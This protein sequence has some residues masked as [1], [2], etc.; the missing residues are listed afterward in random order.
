M[1]GSP[2]SGPSG[3]A[4]RLVVALVVATTAAAV[5]AGMALNERHPGAERPL[6]NANASQLR[7]GEASTVP[8]ETGRRAPLSETAATLTPDSVG[9]E[10][11]GGDP[12]LPPAAEALKD[13]GGAVG[14]PAPTF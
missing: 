7:T 8:L 10:G 13:A 6:A 1:N 11:A 4:R 2:S 12:S 14:E 5:T 9:A 3:S